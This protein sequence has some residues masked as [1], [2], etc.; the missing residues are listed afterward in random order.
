[1]DQPLQQQQTTTAEVVRDSDSQLSGVPSD[2][3]VAERIAASACAPNSEVAVPDAAGLKRKRGR[4]ARGVPRATPAPAPVRQ[5]KEEEDVCF[6]CFDGGSLVLCDRRG[7][8]KAYHPACIKR[9]EAFFRSKA[10]WNCGW[11]ICSVCQKGSHYMCYTCT[12]SLCKGCTRD[13][14]FVSV[15]GN[16]GFCGMCMK[17]IMLVENPGQE[18]KC[19]VDFDDKTSWEYLFKIYWVCL[20]EKL[21]LTVDELRQAKKPWKSA[22]P[23]SCKVETPHQLYH[24]KDDKGA[25]SENSCIDIEF[26]HLT[27]NKPKRSE[28]QIFIWDGTWNDVRYRTQDI[29]VTRELIGNICTMPN[30]VNP[31]VV[32]VNNTNVGVVKSEPSSAAVDIS[33]LLLSTGME[34]PF[35]NFVNDKLW[36]YQDPS[37]MVQGPFSILQLHKWNASGHFP[38]DLRIWRTY[39]TQ[40]NSILL[41]DALV[42]KCA[43]NVSVPYNSPMSL[44][45]CVTL[46]NKDNIQDGGRNETRAEIHADS[47]IINSGGAEKVDDAGTPSNCKDESVRSNG[48]QSHSSSWNMAVDMNEGQSGN[49]ERR[50]ESSKCEILNPN[51]PDL[52]PSTTFSKKPNESSPDTVQEG[53]GVEGNTED[54]VNHCQNRTPEGQSSGSYQKDCEENS[55]QSSGQNWECPQVIN[56][57]CNTSMWQ[58]IFGEP[59]EFGSLVDESVSD[60]L[61]EVE[62][63]E[64][65]GGGGLESPTSIMKCDDELTDGSKNDC[66]SFALGLGLGPMLDA[67]KGDSLSSTGDLHLPSQFTTA[68]EPFRHAGVHQ[69]HQRI[70]GDH[71]SSSSVVQS[72]FSSISWNPTSQYSWDPKC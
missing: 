23:L 45:S 9:D 52:L 31:N 67:G 27:D 15:R 26:D 43:K 66:L 28:K 14:D 40:D 18:N 30:Q 62:A 60:L 13:A 58:A 29:P 38:L 5:K 10:K 20:K 32:A 59:A 71:S 6:I 57:T 24:L 65:L 51:Q 55:G 2:A 46:D 1:M 36:H 56:P 7:C 8:P 35:D 68:E 22:T 72:T 48:L 17:T 33:S 19:E 39:E 11:H 44:E 42:G 3:N 25:A 54:N 49:L 37:G 61:A 12:Y 4:P 63:M 41:A 50:E 16:K 53:H 34:Q 21:S 70:R 64:S 69:H 47:R